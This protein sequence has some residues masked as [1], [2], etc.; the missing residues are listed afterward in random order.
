MSI[1]LG[2]IVLFSLI[3]VPIMI[4]VSMILMITTYQISI[5]SYYFVYVSQ[6]A[7]ETQNSAA[8]FVLWTCV[9]ILSLTTANIIEGLGIGGTFGLFGVSSFIGGFYFIYAMKST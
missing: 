9:L 6:V 3:D 4:L 5:G 1:F 2:M 8:V 7:I